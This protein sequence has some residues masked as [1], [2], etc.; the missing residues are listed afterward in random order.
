MTYR[1][2]GEALRARIAELEHEVDLRTRERDAARAKQDVVKIEVT[3]GVDRDYAV[4]RAHIAFVIAW[5]G[6]CGF[7]AWLLS[8]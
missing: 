7:A 1:D 3:D 6:F 5:S 8:R 4:P 2:D